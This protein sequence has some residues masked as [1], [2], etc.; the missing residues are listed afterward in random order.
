[1]LREIIKEH[2]IALANLNE[3]G[4]AL[5]LGKFASADYLL[6]VLVEKQAAM[7]RLVEVATGQVKLE[8]QVA[9]AGDLALSS[10]AIREKVLAALCPESQAANRLT[11]G[12]TAFLNRSV[13]DR[14]D[15]LG[16]ELQ[17]AL[18]KRLRQE[19][20]AVVLERQYPTALLN[21]V[22]LARVG[23]V[24][25]NAV[26]KL[27][28]ADIV[29]LGSMQDADN[30]YLADK[31]WVVKLDL[32]LRLGE[33]SSQISQMCRSDDVEKA[34][35]AVL[36]KIDELRRRSTSRTVVPE[37][38]LWRR[39]ALYLMPRQVE[40]WQK[41]VLIP[42]FAWLS[43]L[44][45]FETI[46]AWE[47]VL[48]LDNNDPD[49]MTHLGVYLI[50]CNRGLWIY[51][52]LPVSVK[53]AAAAKCVAGS[54]LVE[55]ALA[56]QPTRERAAS[57][58]F[59][60]KPMIKESPARAKE[61][62]RYIADHPD[63]FKGLPDFPWLKIA[64]TQLVGTTEDKHFAELDRVL[65][66]A[67]EDPNAVLISFPPGITRN[68]PVRQY[69]ALL[70]PYTD[71][72]DPVVQFIV[73]RALGE[74]LCWQKRDPIALE[75]LDKAIA[76]MKA[77]YQRC[78]A[79]HCRS[80][81][82]IYRLR[83]EACQYLGLEEE[84]KETALAG[85]THFMTGSHLGNGDDS[86]GWL[87]RYCVTEAFGEGEEEKSLAICDAY[88]TL[89]KQHWER[90]KD[91]PRISAKREELLAKLAGKPVPDMNDLRFVVGSDSELHHDLSWI[92]MA[93]TKE[94]LW[95]APS[96]TGRMQ[97][98]FCPHDGNTASKLPVARFVRC[99]AATKDAV[100]F[101]GSQG[102]YKLDT[103]GKLLKHYSQSDPSFPGYGIRDICAGG[104]KIYFIFQGSPRSGVAVLDHK[105]DTISVLAPSSRNTTWKTEP[106]DGISRI[107][108]DSVTPR[109]YACGYWNW[110][111]LKQPPKLVR[112]YGWSPQDNTWQR[113]RLEDA[114][115]FVVSQGNETLLVRVEGDQTE[116]HFLKSGEK[117]SAKVPVPS[118]MGEP[119]WD[120]RR[121]W[122][123][124]ASG[125]YEI[126]RATSH[127]SWLA[128]QDGN[129]F[130]S[131][132][133]HDNRLYVA[134]AHGLYY[135]EL[136]LGSSPSVPAEQPMVAVTKK[137]PGS[138]TT[139]DII[140]SGIDLA[141]FPVELILEDNTKAK[142]TITLDNNQ[143]LC[144]ALPGTVRLDLRAVN[145]GKHNV[146]FH[147]PGYTSQ[148][149]SVDISNGKVSCGRDKVT[150]FRTRYVV[151]RYAFNTNSERNLEGVGVEQHRV[152]LSH[153]TGF[154]PCKSDWQIWQGSTD[155]ALFGDTLY[156]QFHRWSSD[157]GFAKP[158]P[159]V[160]YEQMK[161][162]PQ[163]GYR[164]ENIKAEKG[165]VLFFRVN[166]DESKEG[167]GYGKILVEDVTKT[168]PDDIQVFS[169]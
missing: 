6:H 139:S 90:H 78:N 130:F 153:W 69:T 92:R 34:A 154:E 29:I 129:A 144:K 13:T 160:S 38:E 95:F 93:A 51:S 102:L 111:H 56:M 143:T 107:W 133:K 141:A 105:T 99:V 9:L 114:P 152:A 140:D 14:S 83:I 112:E 41:N 135:R 27:P 26:E 113:Y 161:E 127:I 110:S 3:T 103:E 124:T 45:Q 109:L 46:R 167:L 42:N 163:S 155:G 115:Q 36:Q 77:A 72:T 134:T 100:F 62:V 91:W 131:L 120:E 157:Y 17:K 67:A 49:A 53:R 44:H 5:A 21:E 12:I 165:L 145:D 60:L 81:N 16:V 79:S 88:L 18:R 96:P 146:Y 138:I 137:A 33:H 149:I 75:H 2:T 71:S 20:W 121:I 10:V 74:L 63:Q 164:C 1:M 126:D 148:W 156:L 15:Q 94:N 86:A 136:S 31:P 106:V 117:L 116:F 97:A 39:Q 47:N 147:C 101:G 119:A 22:D 168:P 142:V 132:L 24:R 123:P 76:S 4:R 162:A 64:Q 85:V 57:Y 65:S 25:D 125:L 166:G 158:A 87:F 128:Y 68:G 82:D 32:T 118:L 150:M 61:M 122:V 37:K 66:H 54:R 104:E 58:I 59:C 35:E 84:A 19:A 48:L 73:H 169:R 40:T 50:S 55:R 28:P 80:L 11:V 108:W 151:L 98:M 43:D 89:A 8:E 70:N 52:G 7:V 23:L 30:E 159:G